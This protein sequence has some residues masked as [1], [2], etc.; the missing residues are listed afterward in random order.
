MKI[1][2][3]GDIIGRPGREALAVLIPKLKKKYK[4][5]L[6]VANGENLAH[7]I[8][9]TK[10]TFEQ[11]VSIGIDVLTGG[12]HI[13]RKKEAFAL[14]E[15]EQIPL[16]R[17]LNYP[18]GTPGRGFFVYQQGLKRIMIVNLIGRVFFQ[19][20]FDDPFAAIE[21]LLEDYTLK[22]EEVA[23]GKEKMD[24]IIVDFHA[25]ATSE[26]KAMGYFL[27]GR[28]SAVIGT[29]T[30]IQTNDETILSE[31]TAYITD[32]GMIGVERS[33]IGADINSIMPRFLKQMPTQMEVAGEGEVEAGGV[34]L[35]IKKHSG[36]AENIVKIRERVVKY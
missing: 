36:M 25:E 7:G 19:E 15:D 8:G 33:I 1:L 10:I 4:P 5:D 35:E 9:I 22:S 28:V 17:P 16:V 24:A 13:F 11:A 30:H 12:N 34:L 3:L 2:F 32:A 23:E 31:G 14:L 29:H 18:K 27:D 6:I 21:E 20:N 26:K